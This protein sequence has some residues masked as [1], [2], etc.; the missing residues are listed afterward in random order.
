MVSS[1]SKSGRRVVFLAPKKPLLQ[2]RDFLV[3]DH[4]EAELFR[5][6]LEVADDSV[7]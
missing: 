5:L 2:A 1:L 3:L 4:L 6:A 7:R